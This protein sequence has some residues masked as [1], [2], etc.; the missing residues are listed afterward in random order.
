VLVLLGDD[1]EGVAAE[2]GHRVARPDGRPQA[3]RH[4][5]EQPVA[6]GV[7]QAVV[8]DLEAVEVQEE[9]RHRLGAPPQARQ[10]EL[11]VVHQQRPVGKAGQ[12]IGQ[13]RLDRLLLEALAL[14][15]VLDVRDEVQRLILG[16]AHQRH[17]EEDPHLLEVGSDQALLHSVAALLAA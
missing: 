5:H 11:D 17:R 14:A 3:S 16:V 8:D 12:G 6:G 15:D 10:R 13:G 2:P 7:T 4:L 1:G 9:H